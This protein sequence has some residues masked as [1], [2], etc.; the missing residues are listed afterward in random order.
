M[1]EFEKLGLSRNTI[2]TLQRKGYKTPTV[3][4]EKCIPLLLEGKVDVIGQAQTGTGKTASF[5]LPIIES[6][7]PGKGYVQALVLAPTRELAIQVSKEIESL[8]GQKK[9]SV[10][11]VYGGSSISQQI[12]ALRKGVDIVVGTPGRT[13]DLMRRKELRLE[14]LTYLVLDEADEMLNMGFLDD[15]KWIL[16]HT[17]HDKRMLCFSATMPKPILEIAKKFMREYVVVKVKS[18]ELTIDTIDQVYYSVKSSQRYSSLR[19]IIAVN[20]KFHAIIFCRTKR[21]VDE[22]AQRLVRD[23]YSA[24]ALHGDVTQSGRSK[25]LNT[26]RKGDIKVLVATDV[27]ARG[28][29]VDD[30][31]HV[32]N[33]SLP[34]SP[35]VYVHRIGRTGRAGKQGSA[36]TFVVPSEERKLKVIE[37][38]TKKS[39]KKAKLPD[40]EEIMQAKKDDLLRTIKR[41]INKSD[42]SKFQDLCDSLLEN[43]EA[44]IVVC[45][46]LK[47]SMQNEMDKNGYEKDVVE[48]VAKQ[49]RGGGGQGRRFSGRGGRR[50][51]SRGR[52]KFDRKR[53]RSNSPRGQK[54]VRKHN[55]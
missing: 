53:S 16:G 40:V 15:I 27:A 51:A 24:A 28:I 23:K 17:K 43:D 10:L 49:G 30:I 4:Q 7:K 3:I 52:P 8:Q 37:R 54:R 26:F 36:V 12:K 2:D 47:Y 48:Y 1:I 35:E 50:H 29:D 22:L 9:L 14:H 44:K 45:A 5:S 19:R 42:S 33:Y 18:K 13:M 6:I 11:S 41:I 31:T 46:L 34:Q 55:H 21:N 20:K 25:I 39:I 38:I 32:I